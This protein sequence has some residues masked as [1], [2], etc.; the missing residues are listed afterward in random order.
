MA[1]QRWFCIAL[2]FYNDWMQELV[3]DEQ[4]S[5]TISS[6]NCSHKAGVA[7]GIFRRGAESSD[8]GAKIWF[9]GYYK[10][11]K[12]PKKSLFTFQR[13]ASMLRRGAIAPSPSPGATIATKSSLMKT[14]STVEFCTGKVYQ[15]SLG[16]VHGT[17]YKQLVSNPSLSLSSAQKTCRVSCYNCQKH[18]IVTHAH[19]IGI[20]FLPEKQSAY[21]YSEVK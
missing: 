20:I 21:Q 12:S 1:Q 17:H 13:E 3:K 5:T 2:K 11:Q 18:S 14:G 19:T 6:P 8:E 10:C 15:S 7:P 9:S 16:K 4:I